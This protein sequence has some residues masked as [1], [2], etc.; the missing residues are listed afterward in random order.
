[1][2]G[3]NEA[4]LLNALVNCSALCT[5]PTRIK[6]SMNPFYKLAHTRTNAH[7]CLPSRSITQSRMYYNNVM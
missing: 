4:D 6:N 3:S 2:L 1:L 5:W 7:A